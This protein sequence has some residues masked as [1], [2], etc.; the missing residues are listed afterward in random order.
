M[1]DALIGAQ[2]RGHTVPINVNSC[3]KF[4]TWI[5]LKAG[6]RVVYMRTNNHDSILEE[7]IEIVPG[8]LSYSLCHADFRDNF[9]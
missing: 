4:S 7:L 5:K 6:E 8:A 9:T 3:R 1:G 2:I